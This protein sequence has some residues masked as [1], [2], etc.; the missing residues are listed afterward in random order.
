[1]TEHKNML[2]NT[3]KIIGTETLIR[4]LYQFYMDLKQHVASTFPV[5]ELLC[6]FDCSIFKTFQWKHCALN[7]NAYKADESG[8][9][10]AKKEAFSLQER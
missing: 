3:A 9:F 8:L 7:Q 4:C 5:Y 10:F 6:R 2:T 1:M